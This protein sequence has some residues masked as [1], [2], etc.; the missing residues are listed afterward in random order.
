M[1][2]GR[3]LVVAPLGPVVTGRSVVSEFMARSLREAGVVV[4]EVD[5][6]PRSGHRW[7]RAV[8]P[9]A[10]AAAIARLLADRGR[11]T[12][13]V[14]LAVDA[15]V[16]MWLT[17]AA[18]AAARLV[19]T[20][21]VLHHHSYA[22][23]RRRTRRAATLVRMAGGGA[24][25]VV[26]CASMQVQL[27]RHYGVAEDRGF[28]LSN[29]ITV[30]PVPTARPEADGAGPDGPVSIGFLGNLTLEKG[31]AEAVETGVAVAARRPGSRVVVAGPCHDKPAA[32][33]LTAALRRHP[34]VLEYRGALGPGDKAAFFHSIDVFVFPSRLHETQGI[35]NIE[36]LA[37]GVPVVARGVGCSE[38]FAGAPAVLVRADQDFVRVASDAIV[39][40]A[41]G[42][43]LRKSHDTA[44]GHFDALHRRA[45]EQHRGLVAMLADLVE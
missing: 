1:S 40:L 42:G 45:Q 10:F 13:A 31:L 14:Y 29:A 37:H 11:T 43:G 32:S 5:I 9:A 17:T 16:G 7:S 35:V 39:A 18:V 30:A 12:R 41:D 33:Y 28:V 26:N 38:D 15:G 20:E 2:V 6:G 22:Y 21:V 8:R 44:R 34:R 4:V 27:S 24:L 25:H 36:A 3:L 19:G 23:L